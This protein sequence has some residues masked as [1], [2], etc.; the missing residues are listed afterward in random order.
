MYES[1]IYPARHFSACA[2]LA[3]IGVQVRHL[4]LFGPIRE[5]VRIAQKT[6][7]HTPIDK[8]YDAFISLLAGAHGLVEINTRLRSDSALQAAFGRTQCA[9][10]SVV[11][12][13]LNACTAETVCQMESAIDT[14]YRRHSYGYQHD[15][16]AAWQLLDVD[17]S[18]LP[19]GKK[20]AFASKGYFAKQHNRRGRQ[21]GRVLATRY[22][23]VVV[24]RLFD[25]TTQLTK[26]LQPLLQAAERTLALDERKRTRTLVRIDAGGGSLE[27]LNW[28][29]SRGYQIHGKDYSN[30][31]AQRLVQSVQEWVDD[32]K[33][34]GRQAGWVKTPALEYVLPVHRIAVRC[35]KS[36]GQ[37]GV[38][39][40]LSTL[41]A[42]SVLSLTQAP[43]R[44]QAD[45][46]AVLL[47]YVY[48]YDQRGGGIETSFKGDHQGL[49]STKR[50]KK[51]FEA[52]QMVMLL[53]ALAHNVVIWARQWLTQAAA[54]SKLQRY[55]LLR[56]VRDV[57][58]VSGLLTLDASGHIIQIVLNQAT[59]LA[60]ILVHALQVLLAP[61][62]VAVQEG[63]TEAFQPPLPLS[64]VLVQRTRQ[65]HPHQQAS[66]QHARAS[67]CEDRPRREHGEQ[68]APNE[69]GDPRGKVG[70]AP[71]RAED[72]A[73][74][75]ARHGLLDQGIVPHVLK[76]IAAAR[77]HLC[78]DCQQQ[79]RCQPSQQRA[80]A[81]QQ[82]AQQEQHGGTL[83]L[84]TQDQQRRQHH[85][86]TID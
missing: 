83:P 24:D 59:P 60:P 26:A 84:P 71:D 25:G 65:H 27:D 62:H 57:F 13:T 31:R 41:D 82:D 75:L 15:Y 78:Q 61:A 10:Q 79:D 28:L 50:S 21:L 70:A 49:G 74:H 6:V 33:V 77:Q 81:I 80:Q 2:S 38:G 72:A 69:I 48:L 76:A 68:R 1:S 14:I 36:N 30:R 53:G 86:G 29:L 32:P 22:E 44:C 58:H 18:G 63:K 47:S 4:D 35:R 64:P 54:P 67:Q 43:A 40:L 16:R 17:M 3:A 56:M 85:P 23:E 8:L 20:A 73:Q 52:Q 7:K 55:G 66:H 45:P 42:A 46:A 19:C 11:Q 39:V 37:W 5:N 12:E 9:E 51:R 34:Q